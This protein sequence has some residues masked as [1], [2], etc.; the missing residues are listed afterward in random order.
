MRKTETGSEREREGPADKEDIKKTTAQNKILESE[1]M[2]V[3]LGLRVK[4]K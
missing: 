3:L 2:K 1:E 4:H